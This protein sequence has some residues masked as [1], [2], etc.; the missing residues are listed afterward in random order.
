M[1]LSSSSSPS[2][3][4]SSCSCFRWQPL[5]SVAHWTESSYPSPSALSRGSNSP[6]PQ[7][8]VSTAPSGSPRATSAA[9]S[10]GCTCATFP[11]SASP[12]SPATL[13]EAPFPAASG[14][15]PPSSKSTSPITPSRRPLVGPHRTPDAG[16]QVA[17][18]LRKNQFTRATGLATLLRLEILD[19]EIPNL[20]NL[21]L[22][23]A[24]P[25]HLL[26]LLQLF[27]R[28]NTSSS[29]L[30]PSKRSIRNYHSS[31][32]CRQPQRTCE[33]RQRYGLYYTSIQFKILSLIGYGLGSNIYY[34]ILLI[35]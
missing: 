14:P 11:P 3:A 17:Q 27:A 22:K 5:P 23:L 1:E 16:P 13:F 21:C 7:P 12:A 18:S 19:L 28:R 24:S 10:C 26:L 6:I 8:T 4:L 32:G 20:F 31:C 29:S 2:L 25:T 34:S 15:P 35:R 33:K 9:P 30:S